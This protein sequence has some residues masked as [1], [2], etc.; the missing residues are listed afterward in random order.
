MTLRQLIFDIY[1]RPQT[2]LPS[3]MR[4]LSEE[5]FKYVRDLM[6]NEEAKGTVH[7]GQ[8][9]SLVWSAAGSDKYV[10]TED[11][12]RW[13]FTLT[14]FAAVESNACGSLF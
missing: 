13:K 6:L 7:R 1:S 8:G 5:Q 11:R 10:L 14:R 12:V 2:N 4:R 3:E 9:D